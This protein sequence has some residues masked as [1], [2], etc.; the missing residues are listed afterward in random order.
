MKKLTILI[1]LFTS[2]VFSQNN[3]SKYNSKD[4]IAG[5]KIDNIKPANDLGKDRLPTFA[6]CKGT[7]S[8]EEQRNCFSKVIS[9]TISKNLRIN[10]FK[11]QNKNID[12]FVK[13]ELHKTGRIT[14][15][16]F[17]KSND[18]SGYFENEVI[19]AINSLPKFEP[20]IKDGK[21][22]SVPYSF[23][24]KLSLK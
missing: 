10:K 23:P 5:G 22:V 14:N 4:S 2:F 17:L 20:G 19:R 16:E 24:I 9:S 1:L 18:E 15:I 6:K 13:I 7:S 3:S 21:L 12:I 8:I 11:G